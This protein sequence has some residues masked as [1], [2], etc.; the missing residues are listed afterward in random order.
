M[1]YGIVPRVYDVDYSFIVKNYLNPELWDMKWTLF[2]YKDFII[3]LELHS[4]KCKDKEIW[5]RLFYNDESTRHDYQNEV[6]CYNLQNSSLKILLQQI[7]GAMFRLLEK[8][9][10]KDIYIIAKYAETF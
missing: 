5:F 7:N 10:S 1:E 3:Y 6:I 8:K 2:M 9:E 4:I